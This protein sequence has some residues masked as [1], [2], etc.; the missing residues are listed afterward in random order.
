MTAAKISGRAK[1][2]MAGC[3]LKIPKQVRDD[4]A[5]IRDDG[6]VRDDILSFGVMA[7]VFEFFI[8]ER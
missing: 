4:I 5:F 7:D 1:I 6:I 2:V 8:P 3:F